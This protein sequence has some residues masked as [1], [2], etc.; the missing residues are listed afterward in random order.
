VLTGGLGDSSAPGAGRVG[1][2]E[3]VSLS[4]VASVVA[5]VTVVGGEPAP[6]Q[7]NSCRRLDERAWVTECLTGGLGG[8]YIKIWK[9]ECENSK[10]PRLHRQGID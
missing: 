5:A 8:V 6:G 7:G 4:G 1:A 2:G 3:G 10:L 9:E